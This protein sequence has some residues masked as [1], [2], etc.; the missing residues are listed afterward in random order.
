VPRTEIKK[1]CDVTQYVLIDENQLNCH[2]SHRT[3]IMPSLEQRID[4]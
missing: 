2:L 1:T 4:V 3:H